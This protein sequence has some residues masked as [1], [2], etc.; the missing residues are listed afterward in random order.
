MMGACRASK[1][2]SKVQ[3]LSNL[4]D[5]LQTSRDV[6]HGPPPSKEDTLR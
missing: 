6:V 5:C 4:G 1:N 2:F 3:C